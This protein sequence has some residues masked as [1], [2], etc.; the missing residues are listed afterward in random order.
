MI[1]TKIFYN[2]RIDDLESQMNEWMGVQ[3]NSDGTFDIK[4]IKFQAMPSPSTEFHYFYVL[5]IYE[6]YIGGS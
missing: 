3:R 1:F 6:L 4:D 5:V 2:S